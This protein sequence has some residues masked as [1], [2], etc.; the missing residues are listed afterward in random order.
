MPKFSNGKVT[1]SVIFYNRGVPPSQQNFALIAGM[2]Y[3]MIKQIARFN[4]QNN[5]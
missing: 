3:S 4:K 2:N 1:S 5:K